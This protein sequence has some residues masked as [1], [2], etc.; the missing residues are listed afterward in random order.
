MADADLMRQVVEKSSA[1]QLELVTAL[2][3]LDGRIALQGL[4]VEQQVL[5]AS[6]LGPRS[7]TFVTEQMD[8]ILQHSLPLLD[9][10]SLSFIQDDYRRVN[11]QSNEEALQ[12]LQVEASAHANL[13]KSR[14]V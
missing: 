14:C 2:A 6:V 8:S 10:A 5:L 11:G 13:Q 9:R 4:S 12:A 3:Q 7:A 1:E